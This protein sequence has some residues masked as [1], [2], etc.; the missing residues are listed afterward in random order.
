MA[1]ELPH[2]HAVDPG[3]GGRAGVCRAL[4]LVLGR[5]VQVREGPGFWTLCFPPL[6]S[7]LGTEDPTGSN[8]SCSE[9]LRECL[10]AQMSEDLDPNKTLGI[11]TEGDAVVV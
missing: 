2:P 5:A 8:K 9:V 11:F 10:V 1:P 6:L 4:V 7:L 3:Y